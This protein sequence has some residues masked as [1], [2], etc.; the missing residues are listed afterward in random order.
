MQGW[1]QCLAEMIACQK[2]N[3][4]TEV[5]IYGIVS[6]GLIWEFGNLRG[7]VFTKGLYPYAVNDPAKVLGALDY[8]FEACEQQIGS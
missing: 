2:L 4:E 7:D 3:S 6:T 1:G 8:L 5:T